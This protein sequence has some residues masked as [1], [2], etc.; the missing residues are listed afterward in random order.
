LSRNSIARLRLRPLRIAVVA[1]L[2]AGLVWTAVPGTA[3]ASCPTPPEVV[4]VSSLYPG[5]LATG[6]T[7]IQGTTHTPFDVQIVGVDPDGIA[8]GVDFILAEITGPQSFI[9]QTGG[10]VAGMSG[11]P[12]SIGG[13][14]VGSTSYGFFAAPQTLIGIT[15]AQPMVDLFG[16]PDAPPNA[17]ARATARAVEDARTVRLSST[18]RQAAARATGKTAASSFPAVAHQLNMPLAV[19]GVSN[20]ALARFQRFIDNR[21]HL[22]VTVYGATASTPNLGS[23]DPLAAGD[24]LSATISYGAVTSGAIGTVTATCGDMLVGFGHPFFFN[25]NTH[26]GMNGANVLDVIKDPSSI[27][28]GYKFATITGLHGTLDQD[29]MAGVRGIEGLLPAVTHVRSAATNL[30]IP[31]RSQEGRSQVVVDDFIPIVSALTLLAEE[32]AAF[33]RIGDGSTHVGWT[34]RGTGPHGAPFKLQRDN[35]YYSGFDATLESIFELLGELDD[36]QFNGFGH[37]TFTSIHTNSQVTQQRLTTSIRKVLVSTSLQPGLE[38]RTRVFVQPGGTIHMR[39][40]LL[41]A[42]STHL[43]VVNM[44]I[45]VPQNAGGNGQ[46]FIGSGGVSAGG[47]AKS[48]A[49]LVSQIQ[50]APHN[51]DLVGSLFLAHRVNGSVHVIRREVTRTQD[52]VVQ[53]GRRIRV[54]VVK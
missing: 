9:D 26:M 41:P 11:S 13:K 16:Y 42:G 18:L 27:F 3:D 8:P 51:Y 53:G 40:S 33:D 25:G 4:P 20:R 31:G 52:L 12:V 39:V 7:V 34:I 46:L 45:Q 21:L 10:I 29:R 32:D 19:S 35:R 47:N 24:S 28:G 37:V 6:T 5:E 43:Q 14:L 50:D 23:P 38:P 54:A 22:P 15:P 36:L 1:A 2:L 48:F 17:A 44:S 30:D 49:D